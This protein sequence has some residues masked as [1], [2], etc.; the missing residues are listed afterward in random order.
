MNGKSALLLA[1]FLLFFVGSIFIGVYVILRHV[2]ASRR[3]NCTACTVGTIIRLQEES[4]RDAG[5]MR[6]S[7]WFPVYEYYAGNDIVTARSFLGSSS[8]NKYTI[9]QQVELYYDPENPKKFYAM[10]ERPMLLGWLFFVLG[11][12]IFLAGCIVTFV[13]VSP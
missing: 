1:A 6:S 2:V 3:K 5:G 12:V 10:G 13:W 11:I 4:R 9:G 7:L 8:K